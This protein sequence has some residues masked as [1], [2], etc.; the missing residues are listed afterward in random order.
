M[1]GDPDTPI[2][3]PFVFEGEFH[4]FRDST[5]A[6]L[7]ELRRGQR[8][9]TDAII[10]LGDKLNTKIDNATQKRDTNWGWVLAAVTALGGFIL[11]YVQPVA[12][13]ARLNASNITEIKD[14][15]FDSRAG[16]KLNAE[17][18]ALRDRAA[19]DREAH[20]YWLGAT[21]QRLKTMMSQEREPHGDTP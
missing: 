2:R 21:D 17:I 9:T 5:N 18:D 4:A 8:E 6:S 10:G 16:E 3:H 15:R 7:S 13:T 12:E 19:A 20:A 1:P 11:L 14:S